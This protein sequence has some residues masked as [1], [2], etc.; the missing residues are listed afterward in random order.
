MSFSTS[1]KQL[2]EDFAFLVRSLGGIDYINAKRGRYKNKYGKYVECNTSYNH[3]IV[4]NNDIIP[5]SSEKHRSRYVSDRN[6]YS[7]KIIN[8]EKIDDSECQCIKV[9]SDCHTFIIENEIVTHNTTTAL[10]IIANYQN[11][12]DARKVLYAD[13]ENTLDVE[14]ARKLGVNVDDMIILQPTNQ[15][16]EQIFELILNAIDTGEVGLV[17]IDSLGVMVSQQALDKTM[18]DKTY[19]GIAMA[20]TLFSKK[21]EMLCQRH[22]CTVIGI[23]QQREDMNNPY[24]GTT[25]T[26]GKAWKHN[27]SVRLEFRKGK[28]IDEKG[29]ELTRSAENPVG[30]L[31]MVNMTKN[32][33]CPPTR[34]ICQYTLNYETGIDY[35][36][37]IVD[38]A[39]KYGMIDKRGAWFNIIDIETGEVI[40]GNIQ[41]QARVYE[42]LEEHTDILQKLEEMIDKKIQEN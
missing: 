23:N 33:T 17:V 11:M 26:G 2:S 24:G 9:A 18:E 39:I 25:T 14:W 37:D 32:K 34:R 28:Y 12:Q 38:V 30:N 3:T 36:K 16:A 5:F 8:I 1:S 42:Y 6:S 20:L 19:G 27:V 4:F 15:S 21:A 29:N 10:D 31:V 40:E 41:G 7:R 35:L 13:C 22:K